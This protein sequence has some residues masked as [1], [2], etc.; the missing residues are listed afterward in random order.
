[1]SWF[2]E[3]KRIA[4]NTVLVMEHTDQATA[5]WRMAICLTCDKR[6]IE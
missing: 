6:N 4:A 5:E 1:M 2:D 3:A